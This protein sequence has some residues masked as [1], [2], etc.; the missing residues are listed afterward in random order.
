MAK[1]YYILKKVIY[2]KAD[3]YFKKFIYFIIFKDIKIK[4][5]AKDN[6]FILMECIIKVNDKKV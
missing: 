4:N 6:I 1:E 2:I 3:G 5:K